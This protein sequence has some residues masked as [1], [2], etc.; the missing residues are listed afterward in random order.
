MWLKELWA[1]QPDLT[2]DEIVAAMRRK[3]IP[4]GR[5]AVWRFFRDGT[6]ALKKTLYAA[7]QKCTEIT[8]ASVRC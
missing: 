2:L 7:E 4:G 8:H 6:L 5:S 1:E 3:R